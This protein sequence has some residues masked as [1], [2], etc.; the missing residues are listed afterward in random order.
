LHR[1][2]RIDSGN[3]HGAVGVFLHNDI[4]G[5]HRSDLMGFGPVAC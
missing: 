4:T 3:L 1:G 2:N 5:Q